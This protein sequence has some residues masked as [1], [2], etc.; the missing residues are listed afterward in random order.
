MAEALTQCTKI[1]AFLRKGSYAVRLLGEIEEV[2]Q[3]GAIGVMKAV[4]KFDRSRGVKFA[5]FAA[6]RIRGEILDAARNVGFIRVPRSAYASGVR[7]ETVGSL[8]RLRAAFESDAGKPTG[9]ELASARRDQDELEFAIDRFSRKLN[10]TERSVLRLYFGLGSGL[11]LTMKEVGQLHGV[12]E[13][14]ISQ[15]MSEIL[16]RAEADPH[17]AALHLAS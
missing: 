5:T 9:F 7:V 10:R 11:P 12:S 14:R 15:M 3:I 4:E 17:F 16:A 1:A 6:A 13:S 2:A 8:E